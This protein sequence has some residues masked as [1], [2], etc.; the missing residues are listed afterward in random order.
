MN[1]NLSYTDGSVWISPDVCSKQSTVQYLNFT[2]T[3][4]TSGTFPYTI[5]AFTSREAE[6]P[7]AVWDGTFYYSR[8]YPTISIPSVILT[9]TFDIQV[10]KGDLDKSAVYLDVRFDY[11]AGSDEI[12][13]VSDGFSISTQESGHWIT[14]WRQLTNTNMHCEISSEGYGLASC[15]VALKD[16][17]GE[18]ITN[19][20]GTVFCPLNPDINESKA[21]SELADLNSDN[22]RVANFF[23]NEEWRVNDGGKCV[24]TLYVGWTHESPARVT[25][26]NVRYQE[27]A[28]NLNLSDF[29]YITS[30]NLSNNKDLGPL[31]LNGLDQLK[32]IDIY[33]SGGLKYADIILPDGFDRKRLNARTKIYNIGAPNDAWSEKVPTNT[34]VDLSQYITMEV[35]G[36]QTSIEWKKNGTPYQPIS[37]GDNKVYLRGKAGESIT[38]EIKNDSY[39]NWIIE[40]LR[41]KLVQGEIQYN[42]E[43]VAGLRKLASDNTQNPEL[44]EFIKKERWKNNELYPSDSRIGVQWIIDEENNARLSH[45]RLDLSDSRNQET[46]P[47]KI[48][49]SAFSEFLF[50]LHA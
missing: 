12:M 26:L 32:N 28:V 16:E 5:K 3:V 8:N 34:I 38:C 4:S 14:D 27:N 35:D 20:R 29:K 25:S 2:A 23:R 45:L 33:G 19:D 44:E 13:F 48:D 37:A 42:E 21:L 30:L 24:D 41:L 9:N 11:R 1:H 43:D 31:N 22:E 50:T 7:V 47:T 10:N 40:T 18:L 15:I 39:P 46:A 6:E 36:Q 49:L 17:Y